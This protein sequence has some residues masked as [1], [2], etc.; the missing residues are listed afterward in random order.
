MLHVCDIRTETRLLLVCQGLLTT[1]YATTNLN[2][3]KIVGIFTAK[4][5]IGNDSLTSPLINN[6]IFQPVLACKKKST[7]VVRKN[8][9]KYLV[10]SDIN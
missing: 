6:I 7:L 8:S 5:N 9:Q 2:L 3:T 1:V 10:N 4:Q